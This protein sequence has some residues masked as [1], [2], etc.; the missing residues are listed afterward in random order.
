MKKQKQQQKKTIASDNYNSFLIKSPPRFGD[1]DVNLNLSFT[2]EFEC[3]DTI[4][5][6]NKEA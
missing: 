2:M 5:L 1:E 4:S 3:D 6:T